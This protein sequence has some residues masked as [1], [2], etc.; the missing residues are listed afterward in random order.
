MTIK[1]LP[2]IEVLRNRVFYDPD[3]GEIRNNTKAKAPRPVTSGH[4]RIGIDDT[5][6]AAH[7]IAWALYHNELPD[8][9]FEIDHI[10]GD[11]SD[12][13]ISNLRLVTQADNLRNKNLYKT[14]KHGYPGLIYEKN[15]HKCWRA[16]IGING[17]MKKLGAFRCKTAAIVARK[18]GEVRYGFTGRSGEP[19]WQL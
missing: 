7:R 16:Q 9:S 6:Y 12:N 13:R 15:R 5:K 8:P 19:K 10:N 3:T 17:T 14:C 11:P 2:P 1:Q 18:Q 4:I